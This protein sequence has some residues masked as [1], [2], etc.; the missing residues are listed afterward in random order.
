MKRHSRKW[1]LWISATGLLCLGFL[2][3]IVLNPA[4]LYAGKTTVGYYTVYH[5]VPL[6]ENFISRLDDASE[7]VKASELYDANLKLDV[8]LNGSSLYPA[9]MQKLR[10]QAFGWGFYDKVI[11]MGNAN[12]KDNYVE[13]NGYKWN[14]TQLLAHEET[15]CLQF[16]KFGLWRSNP[17]AKHPNWKWEGYP[18]YV[19]RRKADQLDLTKN[20]VRK[21]EQENS[22][23]DG[24]AISF[25]DS[26]ITPRD[27]YNA[28]LLVQY[29]L[30]IKKMTYESLLKDTT[31]EQTTT[32]QMMNW[33]YNHKTN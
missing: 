5:D 29:C 6:D 24:W 14:L 25:S 16:H 13:L 15:H 2:A 4:L 21:I 18:E 26:T 3:G 12:C 1:A 11:L 27:Y 32:T 9:L 20:I 8:C 23:K 17:I 33:F 31:S 19:A 28:W 22:D 10:G 30:D 7:L